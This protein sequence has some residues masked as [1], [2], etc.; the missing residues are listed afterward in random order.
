MLLLFVGCSI[1]TADVVVYWGV[2]VWQ[3]YHRCC[4]VLTCLLL[5]LQL[6][7]GAELTLSELE[8]MAGRQQQQID[9]QRQLLAAKEQRLRFLKQHEARHQQVAA[10]HERLRRLRDRVEAQELKL[11]KLRALRGQVDQNKLN[12]ASL[13]EFI[14]SLVSSAPAYAF[15]IKSSRNK[16]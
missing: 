5:L 8:E 9:S 14:S 1:T 16:I 3:C 10:E 13:S 7:D 11:R 6:R 12:N 4:C 2:C 15:V